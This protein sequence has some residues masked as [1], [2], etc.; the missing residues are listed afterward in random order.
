[1]TYSHLLPPI[2]FVVRMSTHAESQSATKDR[3]ESALSSSKTLSKTER[4]RLKKLQ[5][6]ARSWNDAVGNASFLSGIVTDADWQELSQLYQREQTSQQASFRECFECSAQVHLRL[7]SGD[8]HSTKSNTIMSAVDVASHR[9][10]VQG[11]MHTIAKPT[12]SSP[13]DSNKTTKQKK[14]QRTDSASFS[15][16]SKASWACLHNP[17]AV[18]HVAILD[19]S[20]ES[21]AAAAELKGLITTMARSSARSVVSVPTHWFEGNQA[22]RSAA[23]ALLYTP[24]SETMNAPHK[25]MNGCPASVVTHTMDALQK[26]LE[27]FLLSHEQLEREGYPLVSETMKQPNDDV[28]LQL[29]QLSNGVTSRNCWH[30]AEISLDVACALARDCQAPT[31]HPPSIRAN[32]KPIADEEPLPYVCHPYPKQESRSERRV[33]ALDCEMVETHLG[34]ELARITLCQLDSWTGDG[35]DTRLCTTVVFD[36]LVRPRNTVVNYLTKYSGM[37]AELLNGPVKDS[38]TERVVRLEQVQAALL[39]LIHPAD[40]LVGHSLE[41]DL[42]ACRFVHTTVIDTALLFQRDDKAR[43]GRNSSGGVK[44]A[45]RHLAAVLLQKQIQVPDQPHCSVED[46][47]TALELAVHRA[48][49]GPSFGIQQGS[50]VTP[51]NVLARVSKQVTTVAIGPSQW[52]NRHVLSSEGNAIHAL[53]CDS[54]HEGNSNAL[55]RWLT[56]PKRRAGVVCAHFRLPTSQRRSN[57]DEWNRFETILEDLLSKLSSRAVVLIAVQSGLERAVELGETRRVR[58][59]RR[60]SLPWTDAEESELKEATQ[61]CRSGFVS[62]IG[63]RTNL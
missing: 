21:C 2:I 23:D 29:A 31:V 45:L 48:V 60:A 15:D 63:G 5:K 54:V 18:S 44:F 51:T 9:Y 38:V 50:Y 16:A 57:E 34:L 25:P 14:R 41:N 59:N 7:R 55:A 13:A 35:A 11:F 33:L 24:P 19:L 49:R 36:A 12:C 47:V 62:W 17:A 8:S 58:R 56:G 43:N 28:A 26:L 42:H 6:R 30:P 52:L 40:I 22:P 53:Q 4:G 27:P 3:P 39:A 46:A 32:A 37:T 10:L 20:V 1:M 61:I